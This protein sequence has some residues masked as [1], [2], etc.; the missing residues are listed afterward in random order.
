MGTI[1]ALFPPPYMPFVVRDDFIVRAD[2]FPLPGIYNGHHEQNHFVLDSQFDEFLDE[3]LAAFARKPDSY[4]C[5]DIEDPA[6]LAE[7]YVRLIKQLAIEY[8]DYVDYSPPLLDLRHIG[9]RADLTDR[10]SIAIEI[11][12]PDNDGGRRVLDWVSAQSGLTRLGDLLAL[13]VQEDIVIMR[14]REDGSHLAESLHVLLPS[15]W[16]P[17]EKVMRGFDTIHEPVADSQRLMNSAANVM[18]AMTTKG[19]YVRFGFS[20]STCPRLDIHPDIV[21][22][23]DAAWLDDLDTL[24]SNLTLRVERQTT[25][26]FPDLGRALFSVRIYTMPLDRVAAERPDL[27]PRIAAVVRSASPA[28]LQYKGMAHYS[29]ALATWCEASAV[30]LGL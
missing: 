26:P 27:L 15:G 22:P 16:D 1:G 30:R 12:D 18:K 4:R 8:P 19:P 20:I 11:I 13:A 9:L 10:Q 23:W 2:L 24:A 17:A 5:I 25:M 3:R 14:L 28:V 6:S 21:R 7:V 29:D